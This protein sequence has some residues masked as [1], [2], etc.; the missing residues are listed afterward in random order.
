M[1]PWSCFAYASEFCLAGKLELMDLIIRFLVAGLV[2][3]FFAMIGRISSGFLK[4]YCARTDGCDMNARPLATVL[5][6]DALH[7]CHD[8]CGDPVCAY[9]R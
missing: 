6:H 8:D 5:P 7:P 2:V 3:S 4:R 9:R 1:L